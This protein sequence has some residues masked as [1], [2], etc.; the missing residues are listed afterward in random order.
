MEDVG[1]RDNR[2]NP[3]K[4]KKR[5]DLFVR[6]SQILSRGFDSYMYLSLRTNVN[7]NLKRT[8]GFFFC[9]HM[10]KMMIRP[11]GVVVI[12]CQECKH[13]CEFSHRN[14]LRK[15]LS[16][17][18]DKRSSANIWDACDI[19]TVAC[20]LRKNINIANRELFRFAYERKRK[21]KPK[22]NSFIL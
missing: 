11:K 16:L 1:F 6:R 20:D 8:F 22:R 4:G 3:E 12:G 14:S 17:R 5:L 2:T 18:D 10:S 9:P 21:L 7:S 13:R 15:I 19:R